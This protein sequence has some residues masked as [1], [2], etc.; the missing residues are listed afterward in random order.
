MTALLNGRLLRRFTLDWNPVRVG[1]Y[2]VDVDADFFKPGRAVLQFVAD[3]AVA[4]RDAGPRYT[5]LAP[6]TP[7]SLR[8]WYVRIHPL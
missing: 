5:W 2:S 1:M 4:A 8:V 7:V 6:E 3:R